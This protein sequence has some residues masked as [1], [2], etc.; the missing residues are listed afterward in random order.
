VN[1][2]LWKLI[3]T[4]YTNLMTLGIRRL[5]DKDPARIPSGTS[6]CR[7]KSGPELLR[8]ENFVCYDGLPFDSAAAFQK[9][10]SSPDIAPGRPTWISTKGPGAW[11]T[12]ELLQKSFDALAGYPVKRK[13]GSVTAARSRNGLYRE[14]TFTMPPAL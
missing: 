2:A 12:S 5:V 3:T 9:H 8:R 13:R 10:L 7:L 14:V 1:G 4:G 6:S 11:G